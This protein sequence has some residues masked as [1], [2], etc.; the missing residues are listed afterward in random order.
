MVII[1]AQCSGWLDAHS[2]AVQALAAV[3]GTVLTAVLVGTTIVYARTTRKLLDESRMSREAME[4]QAVAAQQSIQFMKL[5]Y[6]AQLDLGPQIVRQA[7]ESTKRRIFYWMGEPNRMTYPP[8]GYP[9]PNELSSQS[10]LIGAVDHARKISSTLAERILEAQ[11]AL[12]NAKNELQKGHQSQL[13][14]H[15]QVASGHAANYLKQADALL[16]NA[17]TILPPK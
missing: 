8:Q 7:I 12:R 9:D 11:D 3:A 17:L 15:I 1:L 6:E 13:R 10:P 16:D 4:K 2:L 5:Q 14:Q